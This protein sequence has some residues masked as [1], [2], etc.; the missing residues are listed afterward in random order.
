MA[1]FA[2]AVVFDLFGTLLDVASLR[3]AVSEFTNAPDAF[4]A[5]WRQKQLG[6]AFAATSMGRYENFDGL[7]ARALEYAA[8]NAGVTLDAEQQRSLVGAWSVM[9]PF[10]DA[11]DCLTELRAAGIACDVLTNST[12]HTSLE[13]LGHAG[14][15]RLIDTVHSI[16]DVRL[17]KPSP[18]AYEVVSSSYQCPPGDFVFVTC[19]GWDATGA[20]EFGMRVAWCNR[21]AAPPETFG[22]APMWTVSSLTELVPALGVLART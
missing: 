11:K 6:Y 14:L 12:V 17:Y 22:K 2:K 16:D 20:A 4:V 10:A 18:R 8:R 13:A 5:T 19:N 21:L 3:A 1:G 7:T 9:A 15:A